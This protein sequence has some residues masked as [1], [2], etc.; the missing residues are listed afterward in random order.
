MIKNILVAYNGS[1]S[2][3]AALH[4]A[5]MMHEKYGAHVTGLLAHRSAQARLSQETWIPESLRQT[6]DELE[7][8]NHTKWQS[9]FEEQAKGKIAGDM[10]HWITI[11]GDADATVADYARLYDITV[12]GRRDVVQGRE[13]L[14]LHPDRIAVAS[15]RPVLAI[16]RNLR[17][18]AIHKDA[19]LAWDGQRAA[20]RAL[21]DAM[22][23]LETKQRVHIITVETGNLGHPLKGM[24]VETALSRHGIDTEM[25]RLPL[26]EA[27]IAQTILDYCSQCGAGLLVMG[28][29][30]RS[31][32]REE[33]FGGVT[34]DVLAASAVPILFAH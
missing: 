25:A 2:S 26:S 20:T 29:F 5:L 23:I 32:F 28:A 11:E 8:Q 12:V 6:L 30:Q 21:H 10:L 1:E 14:S 22:Q 33:L 16:P 4:A 7:T 31:V 13:R 17:P 24:D 3:D 18:E 15:G 9:R 19:V 27:G 34:K